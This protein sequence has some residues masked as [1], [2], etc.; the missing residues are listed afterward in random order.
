MTQH[1]W[2]TTYTDDDKPVNIAKRLNPQLF[3]SAPRWVFTKE[4]FTDIF[5]HWDSLTGAEQQE[6]VNA[7][8]FPYELVVEFLEY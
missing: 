7:Q 3:F 1:V 8:K 5:D 2:R 6:L 4:A